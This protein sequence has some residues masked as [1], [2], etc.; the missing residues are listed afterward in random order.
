MSTVVREVPRQSPHDYIVSL[1]AQR[2]AKAVE[3]R[4]TVNIGAPPN[5]LV[6]ER[7]KYPDIVGW[8]FR[9]DQNNE[10]E[11]IAEV[12]TE[13]SLSQ[14]GARERLKDYAALNVPFYLFVPKGYRTV[15]Q[16]LGVRAGIQLNGIYEYTL[17]NDALQIS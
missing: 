4:I 8:R 9:P 6:G 10:V 5:G 3:S 15:A 2:W 14:P 1:V 12:E 7:R 11:W 13:Q 17:V 16:V